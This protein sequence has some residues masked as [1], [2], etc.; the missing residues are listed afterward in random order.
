MAT[1]RPLSGLRFSPAAGAMENLV[2][3]PYDVI[4]A[5]ERE[6]LA[7]KS[8]HNTVLLTLP[9]Q[10]PDDRSKFVKYARSSSLLSEWRRE[11][12]LE[13]DQPNIYRYRQEFISPV[14]GARLQREAVVCLIKTEPYEKGVVLPHEQ[15]FPKHKEDR[16][17]L[18]EATGAHLE[19]IYGLYEDAA[20]TTAISLNHVNWQPLVEVDTDDGIHHELARTSN[21]S[22]ITSVCAAF[23]RERV[24]IADGHHRYET[25]LAYRQS[26][27]EKD[28]LIP[29]DFMMIALSSMSDPGLILLPTHRIVPDM[30]IPL[31]DIE[32]RLQRRFNTQYMANA[33]L[34]ETLRNLDQPDVRVFG[35]ALHGGTGIL[36]TMEEPEDA[37]RMVPGDASSLLK[38]LDV[39]ILH[40]IILKEF[41]I[42]DSAKV[43]YTRNAQEAID[44]VRSDPNAVAF[45]MN[46]PTIDAMRRI[47]LGGEKM[48]QKSTF[49][50]PKLLSGLLFWS[51]SDFK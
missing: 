1:I 13:A 31:A 51:F 24:W 37:V 32:Q 3:P 28:A 10:L 47:A 27:G 11:G 35:I 15:T 6:E 7:A 29:E 48:P 43:E 4:T 25:A 41:G 16:L 42:E 26:L 50:Y 44:R 36:A 20:H 40:E 49:Y 23:E 8:E 19:C 17:R 2:A 21:L 22:E 46:P 39:T 30:P 38:M 5:E 9:E 12:I 45:L 34:P 14:D 33:E 18:L